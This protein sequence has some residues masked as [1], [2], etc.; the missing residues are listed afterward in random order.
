M[1]FKLL[2]LIVLFPLVLNAQSGFNIRGD[3]SLWGV[4]QGYKYDQGGS[5]LKRRGHSFYTNSIAFQV[6]INYRIKQS[7]SFDLIFQR[8]EQDISVYDKSYFDRHDLNKREVEPTSAKQDVQGHAGAYRNYLGAGLGVI[9]YFSIGNVPNKDNDEHFYFS[10]GAMWNKVENTDIY[11][12]RYNDTEREEMM[13]L[14]TQFIPKYMSFFSEIGYYHNGPFTDVYLGL[15][16]SWARDPLAVG[17]YEY[18]GKNNVMLATDKVT[19]MNRYL[20][21]TVSVGPRLVKH[22]ET[23]NTFDRIDI[24]DAVDLPKEKKLE[25]IDSTKETAALDSIGTVSG[26]YKNRAVSV[27]NR[28][29]VSKG[30]ITVLIWDRGVVDGDKVSLYLNGE[31]IY[32]NLELTSNKMQ[33]V[34]NLKPGENELLM[35]VE[36]EGSIKPCTAALIVDTG[37]EKKS[38]SLS[39]S[40]SS[41]GSIVFEYVP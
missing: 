2:T 21:I 9:K 10:A 25:E 15:R 31:L 40:L 41:S 1:H 8:T 36:D 19:V 7:W 24:V 4:H 33:L 12:Y 14:S 22:K 38:I 3:M 28:V 26:T 11:T 34:L 18:S 6:K 29:I 17:Y 5:I 20:A 30:S 35:Y 39:S 27:S 13:K 37:K 23:D 32:A 16:Y